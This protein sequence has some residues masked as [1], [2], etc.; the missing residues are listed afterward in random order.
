MRALVWIAS[1]GGFLTSC[2]WQQGLTIPN[3][4]PI[5]ITTE[6]EDKGVVKPIIVLLHG[7]GVPGD[8]SITDLR[9]KLRED[10]EDKVCIIAPERTGELSIALSIAQQA[11]MTLDQMSFY[12]QE[13]ELS[14]E[15]PILIFGDSQGGLVGAEACRINQ[16]DRRLNIVGLITNHAPWG[17][18][19]ILSAISPLHS[20]VSTFRQLSPVAG[21]ADMACNA[22]FLRNLNH[23]D[24]KLVIPILALGGTFQEQTSN[25]RMIAHVVGGTRIGHNN[26]WGHRFSIKYL[27]KPFANRLIGTGYNDCL[28]GINEQFPAYHTNL[29][30]YCAIIGYHHYQ[31]REEGLPYRLMYK[32]IKEHLGLN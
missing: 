29:I 21:A 15:T 17:G 24:N 22:P 6:K 26:S 13:K 19:P 31:P 28:I 32:F 16:T 8:R 20:F 12:L 18:A 30:S 1:V 11:S 2:S 4:I 5:E 14:F 27:E 7:I 9:K 10:F 3:G 25:F 23:E